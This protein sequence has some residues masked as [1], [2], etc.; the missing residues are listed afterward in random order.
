MAGESEIGRK[1]VEKSFVTAGDRVALGDLAIITSHVVMAPIGATTVQLEHRAKKW[2]PV[3]GTMRQQ[4]FRAYCA[5]KKS[6]SML[7]VR[8]G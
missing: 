2:E 3:F 5:I 8:L 1:A 7:Q 6:R 4:K